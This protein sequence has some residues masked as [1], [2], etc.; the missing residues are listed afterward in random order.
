M[1]EQKRGCGYRKIGG[2]YL[3]CDG[4]TFECDGLP[5][6]LEACECCGFEPPFSRNLQRIQ[7]K[8]ISQAEIKH[9]D[10]LIK[11]HLERGIRGYDCTCSAG[12]PLCDAGNQ[13]AQ[14]TKYGLMFVGQEYTPE[15]FIQEA[16]KMGISKRIPE[17]PSWLKLGETWVLLAHNKTP[18]ESLEQMKQKNGLLEKEPEY[19]RAI[20]YAFKPQRVEMPMWKGSLSSEEILKLEKKGITVVLLDITPE[21]VKRHKI[22][23]AAEKNRKLWLLEEDPK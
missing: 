12:C 23:K 11:A 1:S 9:H 18:D 22:A 20:F 10:T 5:L 16:V 7:I 8:Y 14:G 17:I 4:A 13:E 2:L 19:T 6:P 15:S 3:V 21:N